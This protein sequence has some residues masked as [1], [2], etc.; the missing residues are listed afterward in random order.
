MCRWIAF[1]GHAPLR[2]KSVLFDPTH[3]IIK[4]M[5]RS[6]CLPGIFEH[7]DQ[8]HVDIYMVYLT[9]LRNHVIN[10]DGWGVVVY[11]EGGSLVGVHK[12]T[13]AIADSPTLMS[14]LDKPDSVGKVIFAHARA[15]SHGVV[16]IANCHPFVNK[17]ENLTFMHN[18][19]IAHFADLR[20]Q[21]LELIGPELAR[22]IGGATDSEH[23]FAL[24]RHFLRERLK[25]NQ[26]TSTFPY[27]PNDLIH[28]LERTIDWIITHT[29][30]GLKLGWERAGSSMNF[31]LTD[32]THL[33]ATRYRDKH[34]EDPPSLY[35]GRGGVRDLGLT[36]EFDPRP[37]C[38]N[39]EHEKVS[40]LDS[41]N[42]FLHS[43]HS[44]TCNEDDNPCLIVSSEPLLHADS[45]C[46]QK[47]C[48][49]LIPPNHLVAIDGIRHKYQLRPLREYSSSVIA[50]NLVERFHAQHTPHHTPDVDNTCNK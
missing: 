47:K 2:L 6:K 21:L 25:E 33:V 8:Q 35:L 1:V 19:G 30:E 18:G 12:G 3:S 40:V 29:N 49:D 7:Q 10:D 26:S 34:D 39:E 4:E 43:W 28:A 11:G 24:C 31:A 46:E 20:C 41:D 22:D 45:P 36:S 9:K 32:G 50:H 42:N 37:K 44:V 38:L 15:A 23:V 5:S 16:D 27:R 14:L 17:C 13:D 48:W